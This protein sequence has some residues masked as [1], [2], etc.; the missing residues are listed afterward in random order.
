MSSAAC[1]ELQHSNLRCSLQTPPGPCSL[2]LPVRSVTASRVQADGLGVQACWQGWVCVL[3]RSA[4][5]WKFTVYKVKL[6]VSFVLQ[7]DNLN[8]MGW[9]VSQAQLRHTSSWGREVSY[10]NSL[11][12]D[13]EC[14]QRQ[15]LHTPFSS[16]LKEKPAVSC[17]LQFLA[18][19]VHKWFISFLREGLALHSICRLGISPS[20]S[21][22]N[23]AGSCLTQSEH[24]SK[25]IVLIPSSFVCSL[26]FSFIWWGPSLIC[27]I[28]D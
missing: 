8:T 22:R 11:S 4:D 12:V 25:F 27:T 5:P 26:T 9:W 17:P 2:Q 14:L 15:L 19:I 6:E 10:P 23:V 24:N 18:N 28:C 7:Q 13:C 20:L 16:L 21:C 3:D 1:P